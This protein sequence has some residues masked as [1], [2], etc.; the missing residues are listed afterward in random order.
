MI[1]G[2]KMRQFATEGPR[3]HASTAEADRL[4]DSAGSLPLNG[5]DFSSGYTQQ[6][7]LPVQLLRILI[8]TKYITIYYILLYNMLCYSAITC[9]D[10]CAAKHM[11]P[12]S[13][14]AYPSHNIWQTI[15][16]GY[17]TCIRAV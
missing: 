7:A 13:S 1:A 14:I 10:A 4:E 15:S 2:S 6:L 3:L 17:E 5:F 9:I 12:L 8:C 11:R 16:C